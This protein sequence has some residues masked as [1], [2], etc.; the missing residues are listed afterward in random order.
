MALVTTPTA[1]NAD[2]YASVA[3]ADDYL[4][5]KSGFSTWDAFTDG[6]KENFLKQATRQIDMLRFEYR[7]FYWDARDYRD[8]QSLKHPMLDQ[9]HWSSTV[10]AGSTTTVTIPNAIN[11]T[12]MPD[13][14]WNGGAIVVREG[15]GRGQTATITDF[16]AS[17]GVVTFET[18][19]TA[20]DSTSQITLIQEL[21]DEIVWACI[22][23][24][25]F[26]ALRRDDA[27]RDRVEGVKSRKIGDVSE[28]YSI[29]QT[30]GVNGIVYSMESLSYLMPYISNT[31][32]IRT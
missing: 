8:K 22:E 30:V 18:V 4:A 24:A 23:H 27:M 28:T 13:D 17:T 15:S 31:G 7:P 25:Y 21:D 5:V 16:V 20:L 6:Q 19:S 9:K 12:W 1:P 14:Y 2:S 26:L 32:S 29:P 10:S 11:L 3:D